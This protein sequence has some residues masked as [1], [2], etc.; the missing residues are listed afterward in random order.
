MT[1]PEQQ[2]RSPSTAP[3][4]PGARAGKA[5]SPAH[6]RHLTTVVIHLDRLTHNLRI[7]QQA[8][9][10][11]PL[12]PCIK[13]NAYGHGAELVARHLIR[14]GYDT[15]GVA[16]VPEAIGLLDAGIHA[17][18]LILSATLPEHAEAI[19]A[20]DCEPVVCTREVIEALGHRAAQAGKRIAV[21]L[22]VDTG[23]G[24][25]GIQPD[26]VT[27]FLDHC[28]A[29]PA[30][31]VRGLM[32]HFPRADEA[33]KTYSLAQIE[34]FRRVIEATNHAGIDVRHMANSAAILD[35]PTSHFDAVRPGIAM[36]GLAPSRG[37]ANPRVGELRPV[38]EWKTRV[39]FLKEVPEGVGLS[40]GHIFHTRRPSLVATVPVGYG[41]G[42]DRRLSNNVDVLVRGARCPQVGHIT[43]DQSL[44]DVT[45]VRG[46]VGLG[47]E[48]VLIGRQGGDHLTADEMAERLGTINYEIV[49]AIAGRVPRA[50]S[51]RSDCR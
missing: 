9:G 8:V 38:L 51:P 16:D 44:V 28:R 11:R 37:I 17:K 18:Y 20:Y 34:R 4:A 30:V 22:K 10:H 47:D 32:S 2:D 29:F 27:A 39:V 48:V 21:H 41:D 6:A 40:Y 23:M 49:T 42:L 7:L 45:A 24:R 15:L 46:K 3:E 13:A 1:Q 25:I 43:M 26:E 14:L 35:L 12:W 33:N 31:R 5:E 50:A 19:V 36:Y